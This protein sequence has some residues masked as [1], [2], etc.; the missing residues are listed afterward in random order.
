MTTFFN[1]DRDLFHDRLNRT[2]G[3]KRIRFFTAKINNN[4]NQPINHRLFHWAL[5]AGLVSISFSSL[6]L[7]P[8]SSSA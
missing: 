5:I 1:P 8:F 3:S 4:L 7:S 6:A 2:N